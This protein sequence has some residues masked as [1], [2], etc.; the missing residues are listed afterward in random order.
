MLLLAGTSEAGKSSAGEYLAA[1]G[2]RRVKIRTVLVRLVSGRETY[3][4]GAQTREGFEYD[5]F[6]AKLLEL[7]SSGETPLAVE[8]F[9]DV[10]LAAAVRR[11]WP[12][13]CAIMFITAPLPVRVRRLAEARGISAAQAQRIIRSKDD[14]KRVHEQLPTWRVITDH[15]IDNSADIVTFRARLRAAFE[16][17]QAA[18]GG[19]QP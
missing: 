8:S 6:I 2:A 18:P 9:I 3:H 17:I 12:A 14:R 10:T 15:W 7:E 16:S 1:L 4:E 13:R 19:T 11:A 5:E